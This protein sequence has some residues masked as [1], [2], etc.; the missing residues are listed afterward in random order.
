ME[1]G[2]ALAKVGRKSASFY[3]A[4]ASEATSPDSVLHLEMS[5]PSP[6]RS[7]SMPEVPTGSSDKTDATD[8]SERAPPHTSSWVHTAFLL[9]GD[10]VGTGVLSLAACFAALGWLPVPSLYKSRS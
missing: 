3:G 7:A 6:R 9:L 5:R 8:R 4:E 10:I 2:V 1:S